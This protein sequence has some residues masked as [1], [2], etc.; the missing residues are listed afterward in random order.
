MQ[1]SFSFG[2]GVDAHS[3][4]PTESR[5]ARAE[6]EREISE[7][8]EHAPNFGG[9]RDS[10]DSNLYARM[11]V[12]SVRFATPDSLET[13]L[14]A[15]PHGRTEVTYADALEEAHFLGLRLNCGLRACEL[16]ER[17]GPEAPT[18]FR[19]QIAELTALGLVEI[20]E[21]AT[22]LTSRGRLLSN[23]VFQRFIVDRSIG[24]SVFRC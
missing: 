19:E 14:A 5:Q 7:Y 22:R 16:A 1:K 9:A 20:G 10:Q 17:Y 15:K 13:F 3:M 18:V 23:E 2:F 6:M 24:Q 8:L 11:G 12:E 21:G 4:L